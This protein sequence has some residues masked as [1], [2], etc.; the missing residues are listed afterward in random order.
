[1]VVYHHSFYLSRFFWIKNA[2]KTPRADARSVY[3]PFPYMYDPRPN[4]ADTFAGLIFTP[5]PIVG[6]TDTLLM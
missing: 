4:Q 2:Q 3:I 5:G 6:A 1:M